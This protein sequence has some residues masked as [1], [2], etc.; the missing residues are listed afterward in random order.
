MREYN[1]SVRDLIPDIIK[2]KGEI[3]FTRILEEVEYK[4]ELEKNFMKNIW[5]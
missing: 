4:Q 3:P 1:K 2:E 5:K